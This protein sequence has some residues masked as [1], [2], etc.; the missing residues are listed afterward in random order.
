MIHIRSGWSLFGKKKVAHHKHGPDRILSF[1]R[2]SPLDT[3]IPTL[4]HI[5]D[6]V[7]TL[8]P[9]EVV[10]FFGKRKQDTLQKNLLTSSH[11]LIV[12]HLE[13]GLELVEM[14]SVDEEK[15]SVIPYFVPDRSHHP[16]SLLHSYGIMPGY[17][18][19]EG[20]A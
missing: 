9:R 2:L 11:G 4:T 16:F 19:V 17:W 14:F 6:S 3:H 18:I 12:P 13:M 5:F 15:I 7:D 8:Y 1:S 10:G 20:S